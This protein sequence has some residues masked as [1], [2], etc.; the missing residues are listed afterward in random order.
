MPTCKQYH[1]NNSNESKLRKPHK[2]LMEA[3]LHW[4]FVHMNP[5]MKLR[6]LLF[7]SIN[8]KSNFQT[9]FKLLA[10]INIFFSGDLKPKSWAA[11]LILYY[12]THVC[13][14][15]KDLNI[16]LSISDLKKKK[17]NTCFYFSIIKDYYLPYFYCQITF[18]NNW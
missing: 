10:D 1:Y 15:K 16:C 4:I 8:V 17:L 2:L 9:V 12:Y 13:K 7:K 5:C 6:S 3:M 14:V 18:I 11:L